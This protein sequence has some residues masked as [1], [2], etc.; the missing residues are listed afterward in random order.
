M[1]RDSKIEVAAVNLRIPSERDR[2]YVSLI[3]ALK[4]MKRGIKVYGNTYIA[5]SFF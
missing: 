3:S 5:I 2:N 1:A 4:N